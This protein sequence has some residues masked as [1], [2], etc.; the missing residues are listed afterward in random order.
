MKLEMNTFALTS[1]LENCNFISNNSG[2]AMSHITLGNPFLN[3]VL[4]E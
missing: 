2:T 3:I 1:V 4:K